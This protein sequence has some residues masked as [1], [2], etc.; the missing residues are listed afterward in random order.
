MHQADAS[1]PT[2]HK[3]FPIVVK[4]IVNKHDHKAPSH[5][6]KP[7]PIGPLSR[8]LASLP[9]NASLPFALLEQKLA[10]TLTF[11]AAARLADICLIDPRGFTWVGGTGEVCIIGSKTDTNKVGQLLRIFPSSSK[12]FAVEPCLREYLRRTRPWRVGRDPTVL[13]L[14]AAFPHKVHDKRSLTGLVQ[15]GLNAAGLDQF[16]PGCLRPGAIMAGRDAGYSL[17]ALYELGRWRSWDTFYNH[18]CKAALPASFGDILV[19]PEEEQ[20]SLPSPREVSSAEPSPRSR[21]ASLSPS[22]FVRA[23]TPNEE[24]GG[25]SSSA[26]E[27]T[28]PVVASRAAPR[29]LRRSP[30]VPFPPAV[31]PEPAQASLV[32]RNEWMTEVDWLT[33]PTRARPAV[34]GKR[35]PQAVAARTRSNLA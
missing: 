26:A 3:L 11:H 24:T 10:L 22:F 35:P 12:A 28:V 13:F 20:Q 27:E 25:S 23:P 34:A 4:G 7:T 9:P 2:K 15:R 19:S 33:S 1:S 29:T 21:T 17:E 16:T 5:S 14:R 32:E 18:Y 31:G 6:R 8:Y 30:A